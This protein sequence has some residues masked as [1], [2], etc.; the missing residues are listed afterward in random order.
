MV[1]LRMDDLREWLADKTRQKRLPDWLWDTL[2]EEYPVEVSNAR[3]DLVERQAL[4]TTAQMLLR[5]R[6]RVIQEDIS[7]PAG[8]RRNLP[9]D[10]ERQMDGLA[11][12]TTLPS[13]RSERQR[14][15][16]LSV[17]LASR[18][19][20]E[21]PVQRFRSR[22]SKGIVFTPVL[23]RRF[24][25][26]ETSWLVPRMLLEGYGVPLDAHSVRRISS[27]PT[28]IK[29]WVDPPGIRITRRTE[30]LES[31]SDLY[32]LDADSAGSQ[33]QPTGYIF[34]TGSALDELQQ[35][36]QFLLQRYWPDRQ[37]DGD[38]PWFVLTGWTP[39]VW[40]VALEIR[41]IY[42]GAIRRDQISVKAEQFVSGETVRRVYLSYQS[43][44][45]SNRVIRERN[46]ALFRFVVA[47]RDKS[48]GRSW[49]SLRSE[50]NKTRPTEWAYDDVRH[51]H[52]DYRNTEALIMGIEK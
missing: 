48:P 41:P 12:S 20:R 5:V 1:K 14:A 24:L 49:S 26:R 42:H 23:A 33:Q 40:P 22:Y 18:A 16:A 28:Q 39:R 35:V 27:G 38:V 7:S 44:N 31:M 45:G 21:L 29:F 10:G 25:K 46:L 19:A 6:S 37:A 32:T 50:W 2:S 15:R 51:F 13:T 8:T 36:T 3:A 43:G 4:L 52:R 9:R 17:G 34:C 11:D 30:E 47:R